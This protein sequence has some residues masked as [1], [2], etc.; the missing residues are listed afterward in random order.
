SAAESSAAIQIDQDE[1][2]TLLFTYPQALDEA[3]YGSGG[4]VRSQIRLEFGA[5][6]EL[7][8]AH[9]DRVRS[10]A[11]SEFPAL[12][13]QPEATVNVLDIER[14]MWE[15]ATILHRIAHVGVA[16]NRERVSRHYY[17]FARLT[18][19]P[20]GEAALSDTDLL[21]RVAEYNTV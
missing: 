17:D 10:Y 4:Y 12:F 21:I 5:R 7:W 15:K 6:G 2:Q 19:D 8:P 16:E 3:E 9:R 14:T 11:A 13:A 18:D 1:H 20:R